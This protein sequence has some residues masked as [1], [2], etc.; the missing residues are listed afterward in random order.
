LHKDG[1]VFPAE[2]STAR[3]EIGGSQYVA[4]FF[5]DI[6]ERRRAEAALRASELRHRTL[7]NATSAVTWSCPPSGHHV[8]AQPQ[9]MAFTGQTAEEM[10][11]AGWARVIHP[12]DLS[13]VAARWNEAVAQGEPFCSENRIRRHDGAWRWTSVHAVPIKEAD[14]SIIE[15]FGMHLDI[16]ERK[17]AEAELEAHRQHLE[18]LVADRT[19][20]LA[21]AKEAA[22]AANVAKSA[23]LA[24]MSHEIRTPL[25]AIAGMAHLI[26]RQGLNPKQGEHMDKLEAAGRHLTEVINAI[27]DLSKIEAGKLELADNPIQLDLLVAGVR[28]LL[29][30]RAR[31]KGLAWEL[32][33]PPWIPLLR[34]DATRLQQAL[35][36]YLGNAVKFT[37]AGRITVRIRIEAESVDS[38][39]VRFEVEDTGIG[40]APEVL[41]GLFKPFQQADN[42]FTRR[43]PGT[44]LGLIIT[45]RIAQ[46][47]GGDA[48]VDSAVGRGSRFWFTARLGR[49]TAGSRT[50]G[51]EG[52]EADAAAALARAHGGR[53]ILLV[54]DEPLNQEVAKFL[55]LEA[56]LRVDLAAD[57]VEAV[58]M[59][60]LGGYDL[61]LMDLQMPHMDGL[62]AT[63]AIRAQARH[64]ETP[65]LAMTANAFVEDKRRCLEAGMNDFLGKPVAPEARFEMALK[66]LAVSV[67]ETPE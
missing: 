54:E 22:E 10:L 28:S 17:E 30:D 33:L 44:G 23:F 62:Q 47:M 52:R 61:I 32:E 1:S 5:R 49:A 64:A 40:I 58:A 67:P 25:N 18:T 42:S 41:P 8:V 21:A 39:R 11:G 13:V 24:N 16:T 26:R 51:E 27:L 48:G 6:S 29:E 20:E 12:D 53:R 45:R 4:G 46:L 14:G 37:E 3:L 57:G 43:Y 15:W 56:G 66:W 36:N 59:A 60:A 2:V 34:G 31:A 35:L 63:R 9:W 7:I 19:R 55:L 38:V 50:G 65:I